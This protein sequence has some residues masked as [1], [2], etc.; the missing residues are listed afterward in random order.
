MLTP[1]ADG[2][3]NKGIA[4]KLTISAGAVEKHISYVFTNLDLNA[5]DRGDDDVYGGGRAVHD[6][7]AASGELG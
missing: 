7:G 3:S 2:F 6:Q 4:D 1:L 5:E